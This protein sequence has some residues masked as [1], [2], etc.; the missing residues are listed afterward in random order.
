MFQERCCYPL[1]I[2]SPVGKVY[3]NMKVSIDINKI[4]Y[5]N[6]SV[7]KSLLSSISGVVL[8]RKTHASQNKN[9][10]DKY[11]LIFIEMFLLF[12][13]IFVLF[14][15]IPNMDMLLILIGASFE[16]KNTL[17]NI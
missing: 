17:C 12:K 13:G 7:K 16:L 5:I 2:N 6:V 3:V 14:L 4:K 10:C 15:Q 11:G 1:Y 8:S 9:V